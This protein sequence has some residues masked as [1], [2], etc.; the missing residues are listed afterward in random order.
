MFKN[1]LNLKNMFTLT[2]TIIGYKL[3]EKNSN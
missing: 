3:K 1:F 2:L